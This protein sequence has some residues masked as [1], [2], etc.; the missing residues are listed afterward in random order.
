M[1][2][3]GVVLRICESNSRRYGLAGEG[4][5]D[6]DQVMLSVEVLPIVVELRTIS[7]EGRATS[8]AFLSTQVSANNLDVGIQLQHKT[9]P[10]KF[11][12]STPN[13]TIED[14]SL[15]SAFLSTAPNLHSNSPAAGDVR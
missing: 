4:L 5:L 13:L 7:R 1:Y 12:D 9:W 2:P 6:S 15:I 8:S 3:F 10:H 11:C 14:P